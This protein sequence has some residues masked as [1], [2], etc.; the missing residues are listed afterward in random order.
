MDGLEKKIAAGLEQVF[1]EKGFAGPSVPDLKS[2]AGV[3]LRTLYRYFPSR[4]AMVIGAL[5]HRHAR[6]LKIIQTDLPPCGPLVADALFDRLGDWMEQTKGKGCL[7]LQA[8]SAYP[9]SLAIVETVR[10]HKKEIIAALSSIACSQEIGA[11][12]YVL[13]EG[14][15]ASYAAMGRDA[16][17]EAK[18]LARG[19][20]G[21]RAA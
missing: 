17:L 6:Y 5:D 14:V 20:F 10:R 2:G 13:H 3:S 7:F 19:L 4:E 12:L 11:R 1:W 8:R 18:V 9:D 21:I 16:V 15:T